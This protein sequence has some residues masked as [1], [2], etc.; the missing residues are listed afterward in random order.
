[1]LFRS[2]HKIVFSRIISVK[3]QYIDKCNL[4]RKLEQKHP[5]AFVYCFY[6]PNNAFWIGATPEVFLK[7]SGENIF[8]MSLAGTCPEDNENWTKKEYDEQCY[9]TKYLN[10]VFN[11]FKLKNKHIVG[12][13]SV[14][15]GE[16]LHLRTD[17]N[18][19]ANLS[20]IEKEKL[21]WSLHPTPAVCG[22]P[23]SE[24]KTD[25]KSVV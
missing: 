25:R 1:M 7:M 16:C 18:M 2:I 3:K 6:I 15:A 13:Q 9:V 5:N 24:A 11:N 19:I 14:K 4:F 12:P 10:D 17:F 8:T 23:K 22:Y 21:I 20:D